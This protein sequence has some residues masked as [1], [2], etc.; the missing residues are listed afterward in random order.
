VVQ[1]TAVMSWVLGAMFVPGLL[2]GF[3]GLFVAGLGLV[4]VP[5]LILA[6]RLFALGGPLLRGEPGAAARAR[7]AASFARVLNAIVLAVVSLVGAAMV[8]GLLR[9]GLIGDSAGWGLIGAA[10][11]VYAAI[12]LFHAQLLDRSAEH[13][14]AEAARQL[15]R[16]QAEADVLAAADDRTGV[17]IDAASEPAPEYA[18]DEAADEAV[19]R[20]QR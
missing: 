16:A 13:I 14:D 10:V 18:W 1:V 3:V 20:A 8:P 5:G 4:A 15:E 12:S 11:A 17:R 9:H 2:G 7:S 6:A 19:R